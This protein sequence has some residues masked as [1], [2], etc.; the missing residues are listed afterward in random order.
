MCLVPERGKSEA[1]E[2][3]AEPT[4]QLQEEPFLDPATVTVLTR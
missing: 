3:G 2:C 4:S 1:A